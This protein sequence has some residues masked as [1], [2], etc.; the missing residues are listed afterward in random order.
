MTAQSRNIAVTGIRWIGA[1]AIGFVAATP[2]FT[3]TTAT[4][5]QQILEELRHI[6]QLLERQTNQLPSI[7][8]RATGDKGTG[9]AV[10]LQNV[11]GYAIGQAKAP[12]TIVEFTD[13]Q[14]PFC[15]EFHI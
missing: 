9:E 13:L 10:T 3:Q 12:V 7:A 1:A 4:T 14:C 2:A 6:R 5:D 8:R 11:S 15:S